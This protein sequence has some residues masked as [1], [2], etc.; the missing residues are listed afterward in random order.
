MNH[1][2]SKNQY[3]DFITFEPK[4]IDYLTKEQIE[5]I[6]KYGIILKKLR[7]KNMTVKEIYNLFYD[8]EAKTHTYSLKTIYRYLEKLVDGGIVVIS[9]H[10]ETKGSR[11]V[12]KL[13]TRTS[14]IYLT[15]K[16]E[17]HSTQKISYHKKLSEKVSSILVE[18]LQNKGINQE[19][20]GI[21]LFDIFQNQITEVQELLETLPSNKIL[22]EIYSNSNIDEIG[23]LNYYSGII[24]TLIKNP[25]FFEELRKI[26]L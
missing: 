5:L 12:E 6:E 7:G 13:Y 17:E 23:V 3:K 26:I 14:N 18:K 8:A 9:G 1:S 20:L 16:D 22:A 24:L 19:K 15:Q 10:R 4:I 2:I 25:L 21:L 11:Q